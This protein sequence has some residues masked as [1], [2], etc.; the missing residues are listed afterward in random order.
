VR[1]PTVHESVADFLRPPPAADGPVPTPNFVRAL[2]SVF[3]DAQAKRHDADYDLNKSL[4]ESDAR[5]I[6]GRVENAIGGWR[7]A[8]DAD[9]KHALCMLILLKGQLRTDP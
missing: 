4:G 8:A 3:A 2:A 7:Q 9:F 6:H 5:L 1:G